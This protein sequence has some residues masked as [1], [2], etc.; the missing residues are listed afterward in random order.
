VAV[1][2]PRKVSVEVTPGT[3]ESHH[4]PGSV[5]FYN[6]D[7]LLLT[8]V[9]VGFLPDML[10]FTPDGKRLLVANE[11]EPDGYRPGDA[12]PEG[13]VSVISIPN[14]LEHIKQLKQQDVQTATFTAYNDKAAELRT[15]G[16][17]IFGPG[18]TVAQ[19]LEPEY[20]AVSSDSKTAYVTLQENNAIAVVDLAA[21]KVRDILPLGFKDHSLAGNGLDGGERD[22]KIN[23]ANWPLRGMYQPDGIAAYTIAGETYLV[24]A[25]EGDA[26]EY[27][28]FVEATRLTAATAT[29]PASP[30][31]DPAVFPA[32]LATNAKLGRLNVSSVM[33]NTDGDA[34]LEELYVF[35][36]RSFSIWRT[37]GTQVFDSGDQIE[38]IVK[39][40]FPANFN[41]SHDNNTMD[42]RSDDKGPEPETIT[43][44]KVDGRTYAFIGLERM[45]GVLIYDITNPTAPQFVDYVNNRNFA[46]NPS[47]PGPPVTANPAAKDLGPEGMVFIPAAT[48]PTGEPL[49][50]VANEVSGT[51]TIYRFGP[52]PAAPP[53][54]A[55]LTQTGGLSQAASDSI[56][57]S[58][59]SSPPVRELTP[60]AADAVHQ[61]PASSATQEIDDEL[62]SLLS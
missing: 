28:G 13:S 12:D 62:L 24:T 40:K 43:L 26:R 54:S 25:N 32:D 10:T 39:A 22:S 2:I 16:V 8:S 42:N 18:A 53:S 55:T 29:A 36:G 23:I 44:G 14:K 1:A 21:A 9:T 34:E 19:D 15:S 37:D 27:P 17:R 48:S 5:A 58:V 3:F 56:K 45:S 47:L 35:G 11:G 46:A 57:A 4:A 7:G 51:T 60:T 31:L 38:Q 33:G 41:A 30:A 49:L 6:T 50:V 59:K 61:R 20:I 52:A